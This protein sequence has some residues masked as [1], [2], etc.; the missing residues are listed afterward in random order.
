[1]LKRRTAP[2]GR[3]RPL[4]AWPRGRKGGGIGIG[5]GI[6]IGVEVEVEV[7]VPPTTYL[8][9]YLIPTKVSADGTSEW[10]YH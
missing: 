1:M 4:C 5:I 9:P 8:A 10:I 7:E 2:G 3:R 6:G